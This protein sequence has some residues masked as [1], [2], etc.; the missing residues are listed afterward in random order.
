MSCLHGW[1]RSDSITHDSN[2]MKT[3]ISGLH[4]NGSVFSGFHSSIISYKFSYYTDLTYY[5]RYDHTSQYT[6]NVD[7]AWVI[8]IC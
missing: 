2:Q 4:R 6:F 7:N 1:S 5:G 8:A 3:A